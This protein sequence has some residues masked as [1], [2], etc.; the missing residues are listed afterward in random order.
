VEDP[1]A[2]AQ[3]R[4]FLVN[5]ELPLRFL[6]LAGR[7][8]VSARPERTISANS[9]TPSPPT[10]RWAVPGSSSRTTASAWADEPGTVSAGAGPCR[11]HRTEDCTC[12]GDCGGGCGTTYGTAKLR[13]GLPFAVGGVVPRLLIRRGLNGK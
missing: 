2:D 6:D 4:V 10:G 13:G 3:Y 5:S 1:H 11:P 12:D 8:S 9:G 7:T